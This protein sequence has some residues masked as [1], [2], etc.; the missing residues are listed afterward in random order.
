[1]VTSDSKVAYNN[2]VLFLETPNMA[3]TDQFGIFEV[4]FMLVLRLIE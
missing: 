2:E 1:M 4:V 3:I